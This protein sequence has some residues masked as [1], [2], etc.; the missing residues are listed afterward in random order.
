MEPNCPSPI[1]KLTIP[2]R[3]LL[4]V[5]ILLFAAGIVFFF[6]RIAEKLPS[7][8]YPIL[9]LVLPLGVAC[10]TFFLATAWLLERGGI[11]IYASKPSNPE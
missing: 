5:T 8:H 6:L 4:I 7:G 1:E 11:R 10:L 3:I 9:I 2:G